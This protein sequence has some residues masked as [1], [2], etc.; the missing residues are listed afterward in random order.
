MPVA[1]PAT[2]AAAAPSTP[3][4]GAECCTRHPGPAPPT[5][6]RLQ[7]DDLVDAAAG[8]ISVL[9][10]L[11]PLDPKAFNAGYEVWRAVAAVPPADRYRIIEELEPGAIRNLWKAS[12]GR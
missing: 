12:M 10:E 4:R 7:I 9:P 6:A 3:A 11:R 1:P 8:L 5:P 2:A